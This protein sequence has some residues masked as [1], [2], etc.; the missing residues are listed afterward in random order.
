MTYTK[1]LAEIVKARQQREEMAQKNALE[2]SKIAEKKALDQQNTLLNQER[3]N[4]DANKVEADIRKSD[5]QSQEI[6]AKTITE[7]LNQEQGGERKPAGKADPNKAVA[8]L[9][10]TPPTPDQIKKDESMVAPPTDEEPPVPSSAGVPSPSSDPGVQPPSLP[11]TVPVKPSKEY[12]KMLEGHLSYLGDMYHRKQARTLQKQQAEADKS[13]KERQ[14]I[15]KK[16]VT[17]H[18]K[19]IVSID[20]MRNNLKT[21]RDN[22]PLR[23]QILKNTHWGL[24]VAS[25]I[26]AGIQG[27]LVTMGARDKVIDVLQQMVDREYQ[28]QIN[29][30]ESN[31]GALSDEMN[32]LQWNYSA[33]NDMLSAQL[34]MRGQ[35]WDMVNDNYE[36]QLKGLERENLSREKQLEIGGMLE[37]IK[38]NSAKS[39]NEAQQQAFENKL[40]LFKETKKG[41]NISDV[42]KIR[43]DAREQAKF[44]GKHFYRYKTP[45]GNYK[46]YVLSEKRKNKIDE[47][48][49]G[50][51]KAVLLAKDIQK[52]SR[53]LRLRMFQNLGLPHWQVFLDLKDLKKL[54]ES[55][56]LW[57][58]C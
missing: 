28:D 54:R 5:K 41:S 6:E 56:R 46:D 51:N 11:K 57:Q 16:I 8:D 50:S 38:Q 32:L 12:Q 13:M 35:L 39:W 30:W 17:A 18:D 43:K 31:K 53:E 36:N 26:H 48:A 27:Y 29:E 3:L 58:L 45:K 14:E 55:L 40:S 47:T 1:N 19:A 33:T 21:L 25:A 9:D 10:K 24:K 34:G 2:V 44:E 52:V 49:A 7:L 37:A 15:F 20:K 4:I 23:N 42:L 22:P